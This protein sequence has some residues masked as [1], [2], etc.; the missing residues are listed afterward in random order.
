MTQINMEEQT[1]IEQQS[2]QAD[3]KPV[4]QEKVSISSRISKYG[5]YDRLQC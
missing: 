4:A 3:N 2:V 5:K 1:A